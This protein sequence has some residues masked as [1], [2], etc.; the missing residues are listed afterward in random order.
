VECRSS[1]AHYGL[2][3]ASRPV[4]VWNMVTGLIN[5]LSIGAHNAGPTQ[6]LCDRVMVTSRKILLIPTLC[7]YSRARQLGLERT[8]DDRS[9]M[10][11]W[12]EVVFTSFMMFLP[13]YFGL[14]KKP[15]CQTNRGR[16][17]VAS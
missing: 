7:A 17:A 12:V 13:F 6:P 16:G 2:L 15:V 5:L 8:Q 9:T 3:I 4:I 10:M 14:R 11:P 1:W